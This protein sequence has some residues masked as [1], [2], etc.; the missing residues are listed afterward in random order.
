MTRTGTVKWM[1]TPDKTD[2]KD[3]TALLKISTQTQRGEVV[4]YYWAFSNGKLTRLRKM[5][6]GD[7]Y[8]IQNNTCDCPDANKGNTCKHARALNAALPRIS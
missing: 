1:G 6:S 2:L 5:D 8:T 4:G 7:T 3:G